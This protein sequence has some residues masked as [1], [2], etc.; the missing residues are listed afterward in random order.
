M[1]EEQAK[2]AARRDI[3]EA[4]AEIYEIETRL[5]SVKDGTEE[6]DVLMTRLRSYLTYRKRYAFVCV[7]EE[8]HDRDD[9]FAVDKEEEGLNPFVNWGSP[10]LEFGNP[11]PALARKVLEEELV[12]RQSKIDE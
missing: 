1:N 8:G 12:L 10:I 5:R 9:S 4:R 11:I 6:Y 2:A 3:D 7:D